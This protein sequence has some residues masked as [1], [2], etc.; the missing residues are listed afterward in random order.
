MRQAASAITG[1]IILAFTVLAMAPSL[2]AES[3]TASQTLA[4]DFSSALERADVARRDVEA[5]KLLEESQRQAELEWLSAVRA[6][7]ARRLSDKLRKA[8]EARARRLAQARRGA[9]IANLSES[10]TKIVGPALLQDAPDGGVV[11]ARSTAE[12]APSK[13]ERPNS[14]R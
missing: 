3:E 5:A 9:G 4:A 12:I 6:E 8:R 11:G 10:A 2:M 7:E 1:G 13:L 14:V